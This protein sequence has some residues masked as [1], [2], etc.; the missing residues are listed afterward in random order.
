MPIEDDS[1][2]EEECEVH[3]QISLQ[4]GPALGEEQPADEDEQ[5][6]LD[7]L[8]PSIGEFGKYQKLLVFGICLPAC[9]PCG[10]CAFNQL[11]MSDT[12]EDYWCKIPELLNT[13]SVEQRKLLALPPDMDHNTGEHSK[14]Y[15]YAV[16]WSQLLENAN[17]SDLKPN[18]SWPIEKCQQ[19]WEYNTTEVW[20]S[21]VIDYDL[22]CDKDIYPTIGLAALNVGGPIGVYLF[23]LL[24]DRAGR[25]TSY[26]TCLATLLL[27]S[28]ITSI[29][30][31]FWTWAGS[32]VIVGLTIPAVYQIP[33]II[34]LELVGEN[35]RSFVTVMTCT[36]YTSAIMLLSVITYLERDW[37]KLSYYTSVPFYLYF[38]YLFIMPESP[39]WLLM[40][41]RLEE[42]LK[43]LENMARINGHEFPPAIKTKLEA[44]ISRN[45]LKE[46]KKQANVGVSDLCRTPNMRL[47]T[48]LITLSWFANE[49]VYLGLS[50]YGPSLGSNQYVSFFLSAVVEIPSYLVCWFL[51]DCWGRRWPLSLSMILGGVACVITVM[52]PDDAVDE[53]LILY[54]VSKALLSASFLIIYPFAGELYPT[55]VRGIG[56]GVSSYVG[57]LGLIVIPFVTYLGKENLKLPLVIMGFMSMLG[58]LTGLRLPETLHHRLPQTIEEG[59]EFGKEWTMNDCCTCKPEVKASSQ[60]ASYENLDVLASN[61]GSEVELEMKSSSASSSR[62]SR[63]PK[64]IIDERTPLDVNRSSRSMKRLVRQMS[65]MDTQRTHDGTM[66]LTHW[67]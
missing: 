11:F 63:R 61:T 44:Q 15:R 27:G 29:S 22:V 56:I 30:T 13:T 4:R 12:P 55:Q 5:F 7:D 67:I 35:Y 31:D 10:F 6:D 64:S 53:T 36:F 45:K 34:S 54:L 20:S 49:T 1:D 19:G 18:D 3:Q 2:F 50:Y 40:R 62:R 28:L 43:I 9:I 65:V 23:G 47:K 41:G 66:Q 51:M 32:R 39:R 52:I 38:L 17:I 14:C 21:I 33:F 59:E 26:F 16:N 8:L 57:G 46:K 60:P 48:I 24:N 42:A 25:R 37:V 58:G